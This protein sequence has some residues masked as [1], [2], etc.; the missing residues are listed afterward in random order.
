MCVCVREETEEEGRIR[1]MVVLK[2]RQG[3]SE[4]EMGER[5]IHT[6]QAYT[7]IYTRPR[8]AIPTGL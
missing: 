6:R 5:M 8:S 3:A 2:G 4:T 7:S 1:E